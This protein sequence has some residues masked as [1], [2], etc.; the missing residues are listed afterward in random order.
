MLTDQEMN[1]LDERPVEAARQA[2][3]TNERKGE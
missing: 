2:K 3:N 1:L